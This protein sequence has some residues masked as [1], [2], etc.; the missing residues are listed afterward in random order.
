MS[1]LERAIAIAEEAHHGQIDK[2]GNPYIEHP[3]YVM[4]MMPEDDIRLRTIAVLHDV[5][6]DRS[7]KYSLEILRNAEGFSDEIINALEYLTKRKDENYWDYLRRVEENHLALKVK[8]ADLEHNSIESRIPKPSAKDKARRLKYL[9]AIEYLKEAERF[10]ASNTT[11]NLTELPYKFILHRKLYEIIKK[12]YYDSMGGIIK[13]VL[14]YASETICPSAILQIRSKTPDSFL[15]KCAR[16]A[17]QYGDAHFREM[18]DICGAR[19]ILQTSWQVD[20][21]CE[22]IDKWFKTDEEKSTGKRG[23]PTEF[24]YQSMHYIVSFKEDISKIAGADF[25]YHRF[26][27]MKA[28]I[29]VR[30]MAQHL[31]EDPIR[32]IMYKSEVNTLEEHDR[33]VAEYRA[34][35]ENIDANLARFIVEF[36]RFSLYQ[37][38]YITV[39]EAE[40]KIETLKA[41]NSDETRIVAVIKN[42]LKIAEYLRAT[43]NSDQVE[44]LLKSYV[45][46]DKNGKENK[47]L[48][49]VNEMIKARLLF[50]YGIAL[51][52]GK[53]KE[54]AYKF[55]EKALNIYEWLES[56]PI[57][58]WMELRRF[59]LFM[60]LKAGTVVRDA[61]MKRKWLKRALNIDSA[62]PYACAGLLETVKSGEIKEGLILNDAL[63]AAENHIRA[64]INEPEVYFV[65]GRLHLARGE[66]DQA[67]VRY[68]D[69]LLFYMSKS[70]D[71][72]QINKRCR[73]ILE[74]EIEYLRTNE[75]PEENFLAE[76]LDFV[77]QG[78]Y[79]ISGASDYSGYSETQDEKIN[80]RIIWVAENNGTLASAAEGYEIRKFGS[81]ELAGRFEQMRKN[82][83]YLFIDVQNDDEKLVKAALVLGM[84]VVSS[85]RTMNKRLVFDTSVRETKNFY[86]LPCEFE[87]LFGFFAECA[88]PFDTG[89]IDKLARNAHEQYCRQYI[90]DIR[91]GK[92]PVP[93]D[94]A[95]R[96]ADWDILSDTY[97]TANI[98]QAKF[99]MTLFKIC[100]YVF[101]NDPVGKTDWETGVSE[102]DKTPVAR[103]EHGRWNAERAKDGWSYYPTKDNQ[104][105]NEKLLHPCLT[106]WEELDWETQKYD[107]KAIKEIVDFLT[108]KN[109]YYLH[110]I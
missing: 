99:A 54:K 76:S 97:K 93:K 12:P 19:I 22:F 29:Q 3:V 59:Y 98:E 103:G 82:P 31:A 77:F 55:I 2:G 72:I 73:D 25:D 44:T 58:K 68:M 70:K 83:G 87:S 104:K 15:E 101:S 9:K 49:I 90:G 110:R 40:E 48:A 67:F 35:I 39:K 41:L 21:L 36:G 45:E 84:K 102:A 107:F 52:A 62:N 18:T 34:A 16:K 56:K 46:N 4:N 20:D 30:T 91:T 50:E 65:L 51:L 10:K 5:V 32:H 28:E 24:V 78:I 7:E 37:S 57:E 27:G 13:K 88:T 11:Y 79:N 42:N 96:I 85:C 1:T 43:G 71:G 105:D 66:N 60:L 80:R 8:I 38:P 109:G 94:L 64:K 92:K 14:E 47:H 26:E 53:N 86:T 95:E 23:S 100:G 106:Y 74:V 108:E 89:L 17:E 69:G 75:T 81:A 61:D 63:L 6:E 33:E